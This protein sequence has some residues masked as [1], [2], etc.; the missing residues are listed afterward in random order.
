MI[1]RKLF[2]KADNSNSGAD[3]NLLGDNAIVSSN[4][5]PAAPMPTPNIPSY[6][7][8]N[9]SSNTAEPTPPR[10]SKKLSPVIIAVISVLATTLVCMAIYF[11]FLAPKPAE[12]VIIED[13]TYTSPDND[14][15]QTTEETI[16]EFD[17]Q[18]SSTSSADGKLDLELN[19]VGYLIIVEQYKEAVS[20]LD[21]I[22]ID[23]LDAYDQS[24]VYNYYVGAYEGLDDKNAVAKYRA[25]ANKASSSEWDKNGE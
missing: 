15:T 9:T 24:R 18:I 7:S 10:V 21:S 16:A 23:N 2:S 11:I 17:K 6:A 20:I 13:I 19:K 25:L 8:A 4:A 22:N 12:E 5:A 1:G 14:G 3:A